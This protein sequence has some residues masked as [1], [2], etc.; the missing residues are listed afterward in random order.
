[1]RPLYRTSTE[2]T[3][4]VYRRFSRDIMFRRRK[5]HLL[6]LVFMAC[7]CAAGWMLSEPFFYLL[8]LCVPGIFLLAVFG[9]AKKAYRSNRLMQ[10]AVIEYEFY[11]DFFV[12]HSDTGTS[13]IEYEKLY[14]IVETK[15]SLYP[16][17]GRNQGYIIRKE[18]CS[19]EL[20]TFLKEKAALLG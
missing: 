16:M 17:I 20:L 2:C 19:G 12:V 6:I 4:E 1:M 18:D 7:T 14:R 5:I 11:E 13:K 3:W 8:A 9:E 10:N 15:K